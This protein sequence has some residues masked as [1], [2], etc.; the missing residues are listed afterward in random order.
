MSR[1]VGIKFE[2]GSRLSI[3]ELIGSLTRGGWRLDDGGQ[4]NYLVEPDMT[5][6]D[7]GPLG[8][9]PAV[10][11]KMEQAREA[12]GACAVILTWG[13]TGIGG[14][15]LVL[16]GG[17]RLMLDPRVDTVYRKDA[18]GYVDFEWY[19]AKILPAVGGLGLSGYTAVDLPS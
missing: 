18:D 13:A 19:L 17:E 4:I 12:H 10:I 11:E 1:Y 7:T 8:A 16:S 9:V 3:Q 5:D 2:F 14:S 15:F 6:W